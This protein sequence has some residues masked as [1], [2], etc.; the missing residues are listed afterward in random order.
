MTG[1]MAYEALNNLGHSGR[2]VLIVLND[3]R[4]SYAPTVGGPGRRP[5]PRPVD[6]GLRREPGSGAADPAEASRGRCPLRRG[7][8]G[9][10]AAAREVVPEAAAF[11]EALGVRY[12]GP[13][14]GH[15]VA[16]LER[17]L[18][19]AAAS[20]GPVVVHALT[21]KGRG[22]RPAEDDDEKCLH[23]APVFD[24][25]SG[26]PRGPPP[27]TPRPS[28]TPWSTSG[29]RDPRI[30]AITAAMGGPTGLRPFEDR[31]PERFL[32]VGHRRAARRHRR[33]RPGH[34]RACA[35][36][37]PSTRPSSARALDQVNLDVG[38]HRLPGRLL[39]RPG[40]RSP[41]TT[42]RRTTGCSTWPCSPGCRA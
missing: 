26:P 13:V 42:G 15:D 36:W 4:R 9:V 39:R 6:P 19:Q 34:G 40:R 35:R 17:V 18:A 37:W 41:A 31:W 20:D 28:P 33:R 23:D 16:G 38:L 10:R 21:Q 7:V 5:D 29:E 8:D 24:P 11:F 22:Y 12:I 14:D 3:N 27:A 1:G 25:A 32:D 2:R 30:V